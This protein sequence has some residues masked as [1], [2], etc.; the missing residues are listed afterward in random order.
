MLPDLRHS[1]SILL[2]EMRKPSKNRSHNA[3]FRPRFKPSTSR[4]QAV[5]IHLLSPSFMEP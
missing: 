3:V 4:T 2:G 5:L 1:R